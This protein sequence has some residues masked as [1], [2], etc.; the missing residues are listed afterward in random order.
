MRQLLPLIARKTNDK[1]MG[2]A[3]VELSNFFK[4]LCSKVATPQDFDRL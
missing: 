2:I 4:E 3:L 1:N